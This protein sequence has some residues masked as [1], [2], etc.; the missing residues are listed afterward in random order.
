MVPHPADELRAAI[1][2]SL[3]ILKDQATLAD[4]CIGLGF[5]AQTFPLSRDASHIHTYQ[6]LG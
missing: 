1:A 6:G 5:T 3:S 4:I 2:G